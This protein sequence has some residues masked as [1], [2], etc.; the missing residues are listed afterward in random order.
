[1][2]RHSLL[3][4]ERTTRS[5]QRC[6]DLFTSHGH[7]EHDA[8]TN[9]EL[10]ESRDELWHWSIDAATDCQ[11]SDLRTGDA[12]RLLTGQHVFFLGDLA[13]RLLFSALIYLVNG[14]KAPSEV[15]DGYPL[16]K[17]RVG[18]HCSWNPN[19][20]SVARGGYDFGGWAHFKKS[21][22][23]F[24]RWYGWRA[25]TLF[26]LTLNH[27]PKSKAWWGRGTTRD[28]MTLLLREKLLYT[29]W[30]DEEHGI[31]LSYLWKGVIRTSG[32]YKAQHARHIAQV[33]SRVGSRPTLIIAAM[34]AYDSQW[35]NV[36]EVSRRLSGLFE[37]MRS[38]W[39]VTDPT[40]PVVIS[41]GPSS[42]SADGKYSN[43][44]G[45][46]THHNTFKKLDNS[47]ALAPFARQAALNNSGVLFIDTRKVQMSVPPLRTS[48]CHYDLPLGSAAET[49][50]QIVLNALSQHPS[51]VL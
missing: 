36:V 45:K 39:P 12:R 15:A 49:L 3:P 5:I 50:I 38:R 13:A 33:A 10:L 2:N 21:S 8:T 28:V 18:D 46:G 1:M 43:Y 26:N 34:G 24:L 35:Q 30:K 37:G 41:V 25:G 20:R 27:P 42:C 44:M 6:L 4:S 16:H 23:C 14:T 40:S 32:S 9:A 11:W 31:T 17:A 29:S 47:S 7:W 22:P 51:S 19:P 48:P